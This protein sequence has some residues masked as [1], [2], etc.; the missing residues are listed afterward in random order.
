LSPEHREPSSGDPP[1]AA[2]PPAHAVDIARGT[3]ASVSPA[4]PAETSSIRAAGERAIANTLYRSL[5]EI[6][7]R[8][9]S[10]ALFAEVAR[11]LGQN[12]LGAFVFA[13]AYLGFLMVAVDLGLDRYLLRAIVRERS[14]ANH[15]FFNVIALKLS[16]ALPLISLGLVGVH[17]LGYSEQAELTAVALA[18]GVLADSLARTQSSFFMAHERGGPP[19]IADAIQRILSAGLGIGALQS[20]HG[21]VA[22]AS[23]YSIGSLTGVAIGFALLH[24]T[25]GVPARTVSGRRWRSLASGSIPFAIQDTFSLLLARMDTLILSLIATQAAVGRYGAAY[26]LFESTFLITYALA[27]SFSA[28]YTYLTPRSDPPL[29]FVFQQSLKLSVVVLTPLAVT[30]GVLAGPISRL[31]Y[32]ASFGSAALPL[33]ILSPAILLMSLVTLSV[34]LLVSHA[35][36]RQVV[37]PAAMMAALNIVLNLILIPAASD[38]GAAAAMLATEV[39]YVVWMMLQTRGAIGALQWRPMLTGGFVAGAAMAVTMLLLRS[40]ALPAFLAGG[41]VYVSVLLTV[42]RIVSPLD[43]SFAVAM[44]RRR[45]P[46]RLAGR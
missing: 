6:I 42:E 45:L 20:G 13:V 38:T 24:R 36:A 43:V 23:A 19:S 18:P 40:S 29:R 21:V 10:L 34:A 1:P 3:A 35:N 31:I 37:F 4:G 11:K 2:D 30:F 7:G 22:V 41:L 32:G 25:I 44:V 26:R 8:L 15:I 17:L 39:A 12:G 27:G 28:M 33:R 16:L 46:G 9:A 14:S 5:G